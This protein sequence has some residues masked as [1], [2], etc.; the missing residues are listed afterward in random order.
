MK[1]VYINIFIFIS[2]VLLIVSCNQVGLGVVTAT[3]NIITAPIRGIS[4]MISNY[5][6]GNIESRTQ[7]D[8]DNGNLQAG[9]SP[10]ACNISLQDTH[11]IQTD[12]YE[13]LM[14]ATRDNACSCIAWG[15]CKKEVC[16]CSKLCPNNFDI[17]RKPPMKD[18]IADLSK[19]ENSLSFRNSESTY[20][21]SIRGTAG[22]C[23][24]HASVTTKFNRLA[25]FQPNNKE[26]RNKL[27]G[28]PN[29]LERKE[30]L[31]Y[32]KK[33]IDNVIDNGATVIKGFTNLNELSLHPEFQ[34]Y[35]ADKVAYS[36]ADRAMTF[37]GTSVALGS[38]KMSKDSSQS[39]IEN[40]VKKID[41]NQQPQIVFTKEGS[42]GTTHAV[43]VSH[44][45][46]DGDKTI[47]CI[48][49]NNTS[50]HLNVGCDNRMYVNNDG[51]I[52]YDSYSWGN[53]GK[54]VVGHN[55]NADSLGQF[56]SLRKLCHKLKGCE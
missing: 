48:R 26:M 19:E 23:W 50:P 47:L 15:T 9:L 37:Q 31:E 12:M 6:Y 7:S 51:G 35:I 20:M 8:R 33:A 40:V 11:P 30:A 4:G 25:F 18:S 29:S 27:N 16:E 56:T 46:K 3:R 42:M 54:V 49:D 55:D 38:S 52:F 10:E 5:Q 21:S 43:L 24:G 53:L 28:A 32:F 14:F 2:L 39:F 36:W 1:K 13:G 22:Y 41:N 45:I 44:Y 34:S 17:F